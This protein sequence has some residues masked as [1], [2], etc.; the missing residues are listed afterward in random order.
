MRSH[1]PIRRIWL[2]LVAIVV[3]SATNPAHGAPVNSWTYFYVESSNGTR[4]A[5]V[6][7][8]IFPTGTSLGYD[9]EFRVVNITPNQAPIYG[10]QL[11][12]GTQ[13]GLVPQALSPL[14]PVP[15]YVGYS[16]YF[17]NT[18]NASS[19]FL[20]GEGQTST[21]TSWGFT[22]Y[23]NSPPTGYRLT[24]ETSAL[25]LPYHYWTEFDLFSPDGPVAGGGAVDPF[26][27]PGG[28]GVDLTGNGDFTNTDFTRPVTPGTSQDFAD[29]FAGLGFTPFANVP[30]PSSLVLLAGGFAIVGW[31][32]WRGRSRSAA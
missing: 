22:E 12:V 29:P 16:L 15:G 6:A 23:L 27:G 5:E 10:F 8:Q 32:S 30:E 14:G 21:P 2:A 1:S 19:P 3:G 4:I 9:Y 25:P 20:T 11:Y 24:W 7:E 31:V 18:P 26:A 13:A 17:G 28:L